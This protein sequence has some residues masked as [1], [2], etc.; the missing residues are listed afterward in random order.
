[1]SAALQNGAG[2]K[3]LAGLAPEDAT[4]L[5]SISRLER[6]AQGQ[7]LTGDSLATSEIWFPHSGVIALLVSVGTGPSVQT[8]LVGS[9]GCVGFEALVDRMPRLM[10]GV[11]RIEG[12]MSVVPAAQL[13]S[14]LSA[15]PSIEAA[16]FRFLSGLC[17]QSLQRSPAQM[18]PSR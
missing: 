1:M 10:R 17:A 3:L 8:G 6:P 5:A 13:K 2:N 15:R 11:V 18:L 16:M 12:S 9:E 14:A 7:A 4:Y